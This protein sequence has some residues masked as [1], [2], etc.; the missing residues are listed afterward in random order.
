MVPEENKSSF[1]QRSDERKRRAELNV[2]K[3]ETIT[4][5]QGSEQAD[6]NKKSKKKKEKLQKLERKKKLLQ[7]YF[8]L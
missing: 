7:Q 2:F 4:E 3:L 5:V 8:Y 1:S 6:E